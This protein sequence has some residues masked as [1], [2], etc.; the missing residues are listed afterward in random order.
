MPG[1]ARAM[2]MLRGYRPAVAAACIVLAGAGFVWFG[3]RSWTAWV[4]Q[5]TP[6]CSWPLRVLGEAT[7]EQA[8]LVRCYLQALA[9]GDTVGL[10]ALASNDPPDRIAKGDLT[11]S[12][13]ARA[14]LATA[15]FTRSP[16]D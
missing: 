6:S 1:R 3:H 10:N 7:S 14:G 12:A 5:F 8:G 13:D 15:T 16:V 2:S 11:H 9:D 4:P